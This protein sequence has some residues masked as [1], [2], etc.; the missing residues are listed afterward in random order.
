MSLGSR[1]NQWD[2]EQQQSWHHVSQ[3]P[4][5]LPGPPLCQA[6]WW[7]PLCIP[8]PSGTLA[9][10]WLFTAN[11]DTAHER[12]SAVPHPHP[13]PTC[14][15]LPSSL[16][17]TPHHRPHVRPVSPPGGVTPWSTPNLATGSPPPRW[18]PEGL[19]RPRGHHCPRGLPSA[20]QGDV[21]SQ[22][23]LATQSNHLCVRSGLGR[24]GRCT[25]PPTR[26]T[27]LQPLTLKSLRKQV[28]LG[29]W[30]AG[31][32]AAM[33][34]SAQSVSGSTTPLQAVP[35]P[36]FPP[37]VQGKWPQGSG[38]MDPPSCCG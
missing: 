9:A 3:A 34:N 8:P 27:A 21:Y 23:A 4:Y 33:P 2:K 24:S 13:F 35:V 19:S 14:T 20:T 11:K 17:F 38:K 12:P 26:T 10:L 31:A 30:A 18:A 1:V 6:A 28:I 36:Q 29:C 25:S 37:L 32:R 5:G 16:L 7:A 22:P 15:W